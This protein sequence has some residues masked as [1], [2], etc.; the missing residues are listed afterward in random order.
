MNQKPPGRP[1]TGPSG[2]MRESPWLAAEDIA[3]VG[4]VKVEIEGVFQYGSV[5]FEA[6]RKKSNVFT[7]KFKGKQKELCLNSTNR[8][9]LYRL[10]GSN[11]K[12]WTGKTV[13]LYVDPAVK[14]AGKRVGGIRFRESQSA[15]V[16][17]E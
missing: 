16:N 10:Y 14:V 4:D 17:P 3:S 15:I 6:G 12:E 2:A 1:Y 13:T 11:T 8:R 9:T 5:E 7:V